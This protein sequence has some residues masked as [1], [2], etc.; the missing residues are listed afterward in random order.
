MHAS[1][2]ERFKHTVPP[3]TTIDLFRPA[4]PH[5]D[6]P[7][8]PPEPSNC[9]INITFRFYRP[10]F[11]AEATPRCRCGVPAIL[12]P[13]MKK[14]NRSEDLAR[15]PQKRVHAGATRTE[16][17]E[18]EAYRYW[19]CCN[20][21]AQNEGKSCGFWKVMDMDAEGR[22]PCVRDREERGKEE[23]AGNV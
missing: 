3:Q 19:W 1:T 21:G 2:Q 10:D 18:E 14:L 7:D 12:R 16:M 17:Q 11:C 9:R 23:T 5:P 8:E 6:R 22:G 20:A 13:D 4:Y 15:T